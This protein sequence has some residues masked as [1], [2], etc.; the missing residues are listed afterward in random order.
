VY[1]TLAAVAAVLLAAAT[2]D[3][4][5]AQPGASVR[6]GFKIGDKLPQAAPRAKETSAYRE[7]N[8][9]ALVPADWDP[10]RVFKGIDLGKLGDS[11]PRA[12]KALARLREEWSHAP[13]KSSLDGTRV[14]IAGFLVPLEN[15]G[16]LTTE[17]LLV[18]YFGA[19]IHVP[20]PPSNQI[21]HVLAGTPVK[22]RAMDAVWVNGLLEIARSETGMGAAGY[23]MKADLVAPY[24]GK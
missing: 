18:P 10:M 23:R 12:M 4:V 1:R 2:F 9:D 11:D 22:A 6:P 5:G 15:D 24:K 14:R 13:A 20:P 7:I 3:V 8:W 16:D 21:I 19:C 17:F